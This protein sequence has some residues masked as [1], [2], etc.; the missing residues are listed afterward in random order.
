MCESSNTNQSLSEDETNDRIKKNPLSNYQNSQIKEVD[1]KNPTERDNYI[2]Q[3]YQNS[4]TSKQM[5]LIESTIVIDRKK[6]IE[7]AKKAI[8]ELTS[9]EK[10]NGNA[11]K[12]HLLNQESKYMNYFSG[13]RKLKDF[14]KSF[15]DLSGIEEISNYT[16]FSQFKNK[17]LSM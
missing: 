14:Y 7:D 8:S 13:C 15:A 1:K 16:R 5:T 10:N 3:D 4:I 9:D 12:Q 2:E 6:L 17:I 11:F